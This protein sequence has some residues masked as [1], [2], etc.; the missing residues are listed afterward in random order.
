MTDKN[1][2]TLAMMI[3]FESLRVNHDSGIP[4]GKQISTG[5]QCYIDK[6]LLRN[7]NEI[8]L[9]TSGSGKSQNAKEKALFYAL[10][11]DGNI[12][13]VDPD[14]E[15]FPLVNVMGGTTIHLGQDSLNAFDMFDGYGFGSDPIKE[16]SDFI[17]TLIERIIN[18]DNY[19]DE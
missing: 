1:T 10:L 8:I 3:P 12:V 16:K 17:I 5:E 11:T 19:F 6:R 15:Y 14:G 7:G 18:N 2:E 13:F 9:G 4:Y